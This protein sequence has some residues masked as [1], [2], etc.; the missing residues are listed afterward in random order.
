ML[1]GYYKKWWEMITG[2]I[3]LAV[4]HKFSTCVGNWSFT[5]IVISRSEWNEPEILSLH[6]PTKPKEQRLSEYC[7]RDKWLISA[8]T[9]RVGTDTDSESL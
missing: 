6:W 1:L 5:F 7:N 2:A 4:H 3:Y 8:S 9:Q